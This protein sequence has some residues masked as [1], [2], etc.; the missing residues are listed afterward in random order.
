MGQLNKAKSA[1]SGAK[2]PKPKKKASGNSEDGKK[3][4]KKM[5]ELEE[6]CVDQ[7]TQI[8]RLETKVSKL[9]NYCN[10]LESEKMKANNANLMQRLKVKELKARLFE[11]EGDSAEL[12]D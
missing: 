9:K 6:K 5:E 7:E 4:R 2:S 10:E 8:R 1:R 12:Q 11:L 3:M